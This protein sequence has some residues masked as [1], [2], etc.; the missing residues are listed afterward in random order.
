MKA[1]A[2]FA[3]A[4]LLYMRRLRPPISLL[5]ASLLLANAD[6]AQVLARPG[7]AG[8]GVT[9]ETW[10]PRAVFYRLDPATFQDSN[11]DGRGDLA[12]VAQRMDYLQSLGVDAII[13]APAAASPQLSPG[14]MSGGFDDLARQASLHHVRV[15]VA[16]EASTVQQ[17]SGNGLLATA[18]SWLTQGAAGFFL[19][20]RLLASPQLSPDLLHQLRAL[21]ASFP[22]ERILLSAAAPADNAPLAEALHRDVQLIATAPLAGGDTAPDAAALRS[23]VLAATDEVSAAVSPRSGARY[24]PTLSGLPLLV[25]A[26]NLPAPDDR[27][28]GLLQRD[29]AVL[30]LV[31]RSAVLLDYGEELGLDS[32]DGSDPLMQWTPSNRTVPP[33][34][35]PQIPTSFDTIEYKAYTPYVAPLPRSLNPPPPPLPMAYVSEKPDPL[36]L[37]GFSS[38]APDASLS[39]LAAPNGATANVVTEDAQPYSLLNLY[40]HLIQLH[41]QNPSLHDGAQVFLNHDADDVLVWLRRPTPSARI[42]TTVLAVCN[43]SGHNL[44]LNLNHELQSLRMP[45]GE[46]TTFVSS[47]PIPFEDSQDIVLPAGG[48][49]LGEFSR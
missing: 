44:H 41:H 33:K 20:S 7:W 22:G 47:S 12:G 9:V 17:P 4:L 38:V 40:R 8:S 6:S 13:L 39:A 23:D 48:A 30:L 25:A 28:R 15:L 26:R 45:Y 27:Q 49:F 10:W 18:R 16:L 1:G 42:S 29:L 43:L 31:S 35:L 21:V 24:R 37:P 2:R 46:L 32:A 14:D 3:A 19:N 5:L 34:P 36:T 11:G